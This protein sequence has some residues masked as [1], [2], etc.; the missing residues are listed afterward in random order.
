MAKKSPTKRA[1]KVPAGKVA[2][3]K[4][5]ARRAAAGKKRKATTKKKRKATTKRKEPRDV[6]ALITAGASVESV[7]PATRRDDLTAWFNL[8]M[9]LEVEP[10]SNTYRAKLGDLKWFLGYLA[11][12]QRSC[13][14]VPTSP[15]IAPV[16]Q[17]VSSQFPCLSLPCR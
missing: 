9:S 8:Y 1:A 5:P 6:T 15:V 11:Q 2:K 16:Y 3:V 12:N 13:H 17:G 4:E 10:G 7:V 14:E